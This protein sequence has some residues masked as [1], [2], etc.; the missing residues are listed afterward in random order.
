MNY[1][2]FARVFFIIMLTKKCT[3]CKLIILRKVSLYIIGSK[4]FQNQ[5]QNAIHTVTSRARVWIEAKCSTTPG[6][7]SSPPT[8]VLN[9]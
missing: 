9:Y 6:T 7:T 5:C 4:S 3:K 8:S 2:L 1:N